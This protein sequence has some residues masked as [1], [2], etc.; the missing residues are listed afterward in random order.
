MFYALSDRF[1]GDLPREYTHGFANTKEV[2]CFQTRAARDAWL[3]DT[4]LL[5][6]RPLTRD[7]AIRAADTSDGHLAPYG[8]KVARIHG[9]EFAQHVIRA[10]RSIYQ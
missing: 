5:T 1:T 9:E 6:A 4:K 7:E 2:I 10:S 3:Q 8:A